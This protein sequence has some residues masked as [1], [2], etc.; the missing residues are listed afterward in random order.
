MDSLQDEISDRQLVNAVEQ[1]EHENFLSGLTDLELVQAVEEIE[2]HFDWGSVTDYELLQDVH[3][4]EFQEQHWS[5]DVSDLQLLQEVILIESSLNHLLE[6][7][8]PVPVTPHLLNQYQGSSVPMPTLR[9][10]VVY[11]PKWTRCN[12]NHHLI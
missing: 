7:S 1:V 6:S 2:S 12:A 4:L 9:N 8:A 3:D 10:D 5:S 11:I